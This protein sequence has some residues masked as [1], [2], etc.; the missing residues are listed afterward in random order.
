MASDDKRELDLLSCHAADLLPLEM[1]W[2]GTPRSPQILIETPYRQLIPFSPFDPD[3]SDANMLIAGASGH[4]KSMMTGQLLLQAARQDTRV[5]IIER[6]DSYRNLVEYM[7][8]EMI[9]MALDSD[10][11]L[12]PWDLE[13]GES[14]PSREQVAFLKGLTRHMLGNVEVSDV[15]DNVLVDAIERTY[16]R[17]AM[18]PGN[19]IPTIVAVIV[20]SA[21][22]YFTV[23]SR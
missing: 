16:R 11:T 5:S 22:A 17:A 12:N 10:Q 19:T 21:F 18:R 14:E 2:T 13:A 8:G 20:V 23:V 4:G 9:T 15:L 6:G 1:P 3:F 7:G